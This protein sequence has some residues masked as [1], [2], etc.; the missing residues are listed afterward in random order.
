MKRLHISLNVGDL[1]KSVEFYS[2]LFQA[3]PQELKQDYAKWL[4]DDPRVNFV[5]EAVDGEGG[6]GHMGMQAESPAELTDILDRMQHAPAPYQE[7]GVT[8]CCYA[9]SEKSWTQDPDGIMWEGF[10]TFHQMPERGAKAIVPQAEVGC[11][12]G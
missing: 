1:D 11:C 7:E 9:K 2:S 8:H 12:G 10:Y 6:L 3:R 4:L 5:L